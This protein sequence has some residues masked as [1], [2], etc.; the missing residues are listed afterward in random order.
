MIPTSCSWLATQQN[1]F[2]VSY[3]E[4]SLVFFDTVE[5]T[6]TNVA[7]PRAD[8]LISK[9]I[10]HPQTNLVISGH[11]DGHITMFDFAASKVT[12]T[13][14]Q[15]HATQISSLALS[16]TGLQLISGCHGGA[17]KVWDL[18]KVGVALCSVESAHMN[19]YDE[20]VMSLT[21]HPNQPLLVSTGA[22]SLVKLFE[23]VV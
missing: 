7:Q 6:L 5:E 16:K 12:H 10:S 18:R 15:A 8:C 9:V 23:L 2:V 14:A 4:G 22:D 11:D 19:K 17:I 1:Q 3:N 20:A 13:I 21:M